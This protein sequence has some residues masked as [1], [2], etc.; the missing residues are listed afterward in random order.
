MHIRV[1]HFI[2][3]CKWICT[4]CHL[5]VYVFDPSTPVPLAAQA[6]VIRKD[7]VSAAFDPSS[8]IS[9]K[10]SQKSIQLSKLYFMSRKQVLCL[11]HWMGS[12]CNSYSDMEIVVFYPPLPPSFLFLFF[13]SFLLSL[14]FLSFFPISS[15]S[16]SLWNTSFHLFPCLFPDLMYIT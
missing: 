7:V 14:L 9:T 4:H 6:N 1:C 10:A 16:I 2:H 13:F 15:D 12:I 8:T 11:L 3:E 5:S